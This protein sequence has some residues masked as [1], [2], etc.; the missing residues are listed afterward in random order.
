MVD[1]FAIFVEI[2]KFTCPV[3]ADCKDIYA[4]PFYVIDF[5]PLIFL[6]YDFIS[7]TGLSDS[8]HSLHKRLLHVDFA[9]CSVEIIGCNTHNE[10]VA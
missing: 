6:N 8:F 1:D 9:T 7:N 3:G 4:K 2:I 10:I 5:L